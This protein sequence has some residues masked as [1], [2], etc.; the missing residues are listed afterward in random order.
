MHLLSSVGAV[1]EVG[2]KAVDEN[3]LTNII[4]SDMDKQKQTLKRRWYLVYRDEDASELNRSFISWFNS[5][6]QDHHFE[7][8]VRCFSSLQTPRI[9]AEHYGNIDCVPM[10][11]TVFFISGVEATA[12]NRS[13]IDNYYVSVNDMNTDISPREFNSLM[14]R[15]M[16]FPIV[17]YNVIIPSETATGDIET[18]LMSFYK[19]VLGGLCVIEKDYDDEASYKA[20]FGL[21]YPWKD[22][23]KEVAEVSKLDDTNLATCVVDRDFDGNGYLR[24]LSEGDLRLTKDQKSYLYDAFLID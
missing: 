7:Q 20:S 13:W 4:A 23:F 10:L 19:C 15:C 21:D 22:I 17:K 1:P 9:C 2:C 18:T 12:V 11:S 24:Q 5:N 14:R 8:V 3:K 16:G 6:T